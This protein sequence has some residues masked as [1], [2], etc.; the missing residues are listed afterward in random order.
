MAGPIV[1]KVIQTGI[2]EKT[3]G[4]GARFLALI[5]ML[6]M[7]VTSMNVAADSAESKEEKSRGTHQ[8]EAPREGESYKPG[9]ALDAISTATKEAIKNEQQLLVIMGANWCHDSRALAARIETPP[10]KPVIEAHYQ[11]VFVDIGNLDK[12]KDVITSFGVPV[13]YATPT[14]LI[15]DPVSGKV[16]NADNRHQW[17]NA[18][19]ISMED[20]VAYFQ[21]MATT[22]PVMTIDSSDSSGQ[23][24]QLLAEIDNFEQEQA[25]RVYRAYAKLTPM[26]E[27]YDK[28]DQDKFS[29]EIWNEVREFRSQVPIDIAAL[30]LEAHQRVASGEAGIQLKYPEYPAFSW[31][32]KRRK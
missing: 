14:V 4:P 23:L 30:R 5:G 25:N 13:Y 16:V 19:K 27:A 24:S 29:E 17:G 1:S 12:G 8:E 11:T 3:I 22:G 18:A 15:I 20:S 32:N 7:L 6:F 21:Q 10:L 2:F 28:G 9:K 26:L 31:E